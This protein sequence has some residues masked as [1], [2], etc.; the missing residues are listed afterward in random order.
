MPQAQAT[1]RPIDRI[2]FGTG[3]PGDIRRQV[4]DILLR[5][6]IIAVVVAALDIVTSHLPRIDVVQLRGISSHLDDQT[7]AGFVEGLF[8]FFGIIPALLL[9]LT[10]FAVTGLTPYGNPALILLYRWHR[11]RPWERL[12]LLFGRTNL[13]Y[14]AM[15]LGLGLVAALFLLQSSKSMGLSNNGLPALVVVVFLAAFLITSLISLVFWVISLR[16]PSD[17]IQHTFLIGSDLLQHLERIKGGHGKLTPRQESDGS[18]DASCY[19]EQEEMRRC[20]SALTE[21]AARSLELRQRLAARE[22]M[23]ALRRLD[24]VAQRSQLP[25]GWELLGSPAAAR[26]DW[27]QKL[28]VEAIESIVVAAADLHY[29]SVG[30]LGADGLADIGKRVVDASANWPGRIGVMD[31]TLEAFENTIDECVANNELE[32]CGLLLQGLCDVVTRSVANRQLFQSAVRGQLG[33]RVV[34]MLARSVVTNDIPS[35]RASLGYLRQLCE[36]A[37]TDATPDVI[38]AIF[39]LGAIALTSRLYEAASVLVDQAALHFDPDGSRFAAVVRPW[40]PNPDYRPPGVPRYV[41]TDYFQLF[42]LAA[43]T[44]S[45]AIRSPGW[46]SDPVAVSCRFAD[47]LTDRVKRVR[48]IVRRIG[49]IAKYDD[50][51][52]A[53][54]EAQVDDLDRILARAGSSVLG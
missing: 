42:L 54:W 50:K 43:M 5:V 30:C 26:P 19:E 16:R 32:L 20:V 22:A 7:R 31:R 44:R 41:S 35:L 24:D 8:K 36:S 18:E 28:F 51:E 53:D 46:A 34:E 47:G 6:V 40:P 12:F 23:L 52:L 25:E 45:L 3:L 11:M 14:R 13:L 10:S 2:R 39:S 29:F 1:S 38:S 33:R 15:V 37:A 48:S 21:T 49:A 17:V 4:A 27:L 9:A